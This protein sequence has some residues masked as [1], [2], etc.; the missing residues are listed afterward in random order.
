MRAPRDRSLLARVWDA[1]G[2]GTLRIARLPRGGSATGGGTLRRG[3][4]RCAAAPG[5]YGVSRTRGTPT[6]P[7]GDYRCPLALVFAGVSPTGVPRTS[8]GGANTN[9][10]AAV[11][12]YGS[13]AAVIQYGS[14]APGG[15]A[16]GGLP[17]LG[18]QVIL[19]RLRLLSGWRCSYKRT[20]CPV[21]LN[22]HRSVDSPSARCKAPRKSHAPNVN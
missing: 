2:R 15:S 13:G 20:R 16:P 7:R 19:Y 10:D 11:I 21:R 22:P 5:L 3:G 18:N 8:P 4:V 14:G 6:P 12:Q 9:D 17:G 1:T